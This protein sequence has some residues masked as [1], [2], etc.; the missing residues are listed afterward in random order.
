MIDLND[1]DSTLQAWAD[2]VT[3]R[4]DGG[5][6]YAMQSIYRQ[7]EQGSE[8]AVGVDVVA[9]FAGVPLDVRD[10]AD[11]EKLDLVER[12]VM[13]EV[14]PSSRAV[15]LAWYLGRGTVEQ[16]AKDLGTTRRTLYRWLEL[17]RAAVAAKLLALRR[18]VRQ[19]GF[20]FK[21]ADM[22]QAVNDG[23]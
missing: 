14:E 6:G 5:L 2:Y 10:A 17:A 19:E 11:Q 1:I 22:P 3:R 15:I 13:R 20:A 18:G 21:V 23:V 12:V 16:K 4:A 7:M 9:P 8:A